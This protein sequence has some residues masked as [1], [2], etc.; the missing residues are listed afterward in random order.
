MAL[1]DVFLS[2][3]GNHKHG[4]VADLDKE[5]RAA[6]YSVFLDVESIREGNR[7]PVQI[8]VSC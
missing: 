8:E 4:I 2:H 6:G 1:C 5:L 3:E 7:F